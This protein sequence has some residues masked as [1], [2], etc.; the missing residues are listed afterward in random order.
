M[1]SHSWLTS[2]S[3]YGGNS[4]ITLYSTYFSG[5]LMLFASKH[6]HHDVP[7]PP[8]SPH[9]PRALSPSTSLY[10]NCSK[11]SSGSYRLKNF[12]TSASMDSP[13]QGSGGSLREQSLGVVETC[14]LSTA[15][16]TR[17]TDFISLFRLL[18]HSGLV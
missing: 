17:C 10:T 14:S 13:A 9:H 11:L 16:P 5:S 6:N 7:D 2:E 15:A 12:P 18:V 8:S 3:A 4:L 1:S